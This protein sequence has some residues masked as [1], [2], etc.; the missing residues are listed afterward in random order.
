MTVTFKGW[1]SRMAIGG[2]AGQ[3]ETAETQPEAGSKLDH[4]HHHHYLCQINKE[5]NNGKQTKGFFCWV[6]KGGGGGKRKK[7]R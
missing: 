6:D 5:I 2:N 4:H 1:H 7:E 3:I